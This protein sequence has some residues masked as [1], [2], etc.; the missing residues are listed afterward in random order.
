MEK[1]CQPIFLNPEKLFFR[2]VKYFSNIGKLNKFITRTVL[3][4]MLKKDFQREINDVR[5]NLQ[6]NEDT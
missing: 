2:K 4:E 3:L 5:L 1:Y 6:R